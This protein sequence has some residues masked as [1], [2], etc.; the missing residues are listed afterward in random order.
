MLRLPRR[1]FMVPIQGVGDSCGAHTNGMVT[2]QNPIDLLLGADIWGQLIKPGIR[3]G[4]RNEPFALNTHLGWIVSGPVDTIHTHLAMAPVTTHNE[5]QLDEILQKFWQVE[6]VDN[7]THMASD[8]DIECEE[9]FKQTVVRLP[10]GRYQVQIPFLS[11][12]KALG[13]SERIARRQF[14]QLERRLHSNEDLL[15]K[16]IA[17]MR[18]YLELGHMEVATELSTDSSQQYF[19]PHHAVTEKFR[20]VFNGSAKTSNGVSLNDTQHIG[21]IQQDILVSIIHCFQRFPV[22]VVADV[23]KMYRQVMIDPRHRNWQLILWRES[24]NVTIQIFRLTTVTYG[25]RSSPFLAIRAL[26]QCAHDNTG[27]ID[28]LPRGEAAKNSILSSFYVDD[29]LSSFS[30]ETTAIQTANDVDTI[31]RCGSFKLRKWNSNSASV[32]Q[33]ITNH[34]NKPRENDG[35]NQALTTNETTV[36]GLNWNAETDEFF[37]KVNLS[38]ITV[39]QTK[40]SI[41]GDIA[42]LYDRIG[43]LAPIIITGK[44]FMQ[45]LWREQITW[46]DPV[47]ELILRDWLKYR[48]SLQLLESLRIPRWF[49]MR[50]DGSTTLHGFCDA[51]AK[52]YG[53]AIY[54]RTVSSSGVCVQLVSAKTKVAPLKQLTI[55]RPE[56]CAAKLLVE[57]FNKVRIALQ[58]QN[59]EYSLWSDASIVEA[60]LRREP[61]DLH[62]YVAN[63]IQYI[64]Q[65]SNV[66]SWYHVRTAENP[67]DYCSRGMVIEK[68]IKSSLWWH[69]PS[70]LAHEE[71]EQESN[72]Q[73]ND[74]E[75]RTLNEEIRTPIVFHAAMSSLQLTT[76]RE[77]GKPINLLEASSSLLH[78]QRVMVFIQRFRRYK[79]GIPKP[80]FI[81]SDELRCAMNAL[82]K[83]IYARE[84][85][86]GG[87]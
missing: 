76:W 54:A 27:V 31:L 62:V 63:R 65:H 44:V 60:W 50:T 52:A 61:A 57:Q 2:L 82:I 33:G 83:L 3:N 86:V 18:E 15:A 58:L 77:K 1:K 80:L 51:S 16:Y 17:F 13:D 23:E 32:L 59:V 24:I 68:F 28:E 87:G 6:E 56:L 7:N 48:N 20:V 30:D 10:D 4:Q 14:A 19:I 78:L 49:G 21:P 67:A 11:T 69:G 41:L 40:S 74:D 8:A 39:T 70:F 46:H 79:R 64:Q 25:M 22:A 47:P 71:F 84:G 12:A 42:R 53:C 55:P 35:T 73:L 34:I 75:Q 9:M 45:R 43:M 85:E 26:R 5:I 37:Y 66:A 72:V 81:T 38:P 36:L 29:Y